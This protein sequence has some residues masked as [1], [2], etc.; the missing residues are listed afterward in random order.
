MEFCHCGLCAGERVV[1]V[2]SQVR[3]TIEEYWR[4]VVRIERVAY[5][6]CIPVEV[7]RNFSACGQTCMEERC[8]YASV[9]VQTELV[10]CKVS[11]VCFNS[12]VFGDV[13]RSRTA[14]VAVGVLV[15][16]KE[17]VPLA[18][19]SRAAF[20]FVVSV[21]PETDCCAKALLV[22][23]FNSVI[24]EVDVRPVVTDGGLQCVDALENAVACGS[25][26]GLHGVRIAACA[27]AICYV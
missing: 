8:L 10:E 16:G 1:F 24:V 17:S 4:V 9:K 23:P 18:R 3:V 12:A 19:N 22:C 26:N 6:V 7:A 13:E 11:V 5:I 15:I 25:C 14:E 2:A 21:K 20:A 27:D